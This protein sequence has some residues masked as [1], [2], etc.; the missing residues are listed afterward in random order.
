MDLG[1]KTTYIGWQIKLTINPQKARRLARYM[2]RNGAL[3]ALTA[4]ALGAIGVTSLAAAPAALLGIGWVVADK[5]GNSLM[6]R[7]VYTILR[8]VLEAYSATI[9]TGWNHMHYWLAGAVLA[10]GCVA[11]IGTPFTA[12]ATCNVFVVALI[13]SMAL[14][15]LQKGLISVV[16]AVHANATHLK[17]AQPYVNP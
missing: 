10:L 17:P 14:P 16:Q 12:A 13:V 3:V 6:N 1:F 7:V 2:I 4:V 15:H 5:I 9:M 11:L 8:P